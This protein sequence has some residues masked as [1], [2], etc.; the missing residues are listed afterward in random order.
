VPV[1]PEAETV[2]EGGL[3]VGRWYMTSQGTPYVEKSY[4]QTESY[5]VDL[6]IACNR[7]LRNVVLVDLL[8]AGFEIENPR[9]DTST[10]PGK[11]SE[12]GVT[13]SYIDVR[14]DRLVVAF[15]QLEAGTHHFFYV[16]RAVTPGM[17]QQPSVAAECMYDATV[18][19]HT[20]AGLIQVV[21]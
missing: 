16:V 14:D 10:L 1:M 3:T 15:D 17:Y 18:R 12:K 4:K 5:V 6:S 9:L 19:A 2:A 7:E 21:K 11:I 20:G 8:P 13:A